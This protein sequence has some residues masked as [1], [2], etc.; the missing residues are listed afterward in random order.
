MI[1]LLVI[2]DGRRDCITQTIGSAAT[3]LHGPIT[4][5]VIH[6][7]SDDPD[8]REWLRRTFPAFQVVWNPEGRQG[9]GGAIRSAWSHLHDIAERFVFHLEDD[10]TFNRHVQLQELAHVLDS[11]PELVQLVL[12]RQPWNDIERAAGGIVESRLEEYTERTEGLHAWLEHRLFFSTNPCLYRTDLIRKHPWPRGLQ[13]EG[14]FGLELTKS[15]KVRF[16]FWG[17][18]ASGEW[19]THIGNERVG[20]GY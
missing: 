15:P 3:S 8:H 6:D 18:L 12:R 13:S 17:D 2:T 4:R 20:T 1:C 16:G 10:F 7:D 5:R 14:R 19:V 11:H 9:F